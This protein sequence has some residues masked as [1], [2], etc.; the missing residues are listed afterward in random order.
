[1]DELNVHLKVLEL[2]KKNGVIHSSLIRPI[3]KLLVPAI[4][5]QFR[6]FDDLDTDNWDSSKS[7]GEKVTIYDYKFF[8]KKSG[9]LFTSGG[10]ILKFI[11]DY[12]LNTTGSSDAKLIIGLMDQIRFDI[13]ARG[14]NLTDKNLIR[15]YFNH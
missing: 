10:D 8:F 1:M 9:K 5:S 11:T 4:K 6:L 7:N 12:K 3:A 14:K 13:H 15:N 2:L